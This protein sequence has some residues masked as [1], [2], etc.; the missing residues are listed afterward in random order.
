MGPV[1]RG[2][3]QEAECSGDPAAGAECRQAA[4]RMD[5]EAINELAVLGPGTGW[6]APSDSSAPARLVPSLRARPIPTPACPAGQ[7]RSA[8]LRL[9]S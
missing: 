6:C 5:W 3:A 7:V 4:S 1:F 8:I 9:V 2:L